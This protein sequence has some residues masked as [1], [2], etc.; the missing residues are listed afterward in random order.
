MVDMNK[1]V[2]SGFT[3]YQCGGTD[4]WLLN[5]TEYYNIGDGYMCGYQQAI[6]SGYKGYYPGSLWH[7]TS[8]QM[9]YLGFALVAVLVA[10]AN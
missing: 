4:N 6:W 1:T 2:I 5:D 9:T 3:L 8:V 7:H 10:F